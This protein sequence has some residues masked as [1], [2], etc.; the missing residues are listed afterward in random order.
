MEP[1]AHDEYSVIFYEGNPGWDKDPETTKYYLM[2]QQD[3]ANEKLKAQGYLFLNDVYEMLGFNKT[4]AG[5]IV[6]WYYDEKNP[7]GSNY[8]DFGMFDIYNKNKIDFINGDERAIVLDF[9][10]DGNILEYI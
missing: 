8:V 2:R 3:W 7:V 5:Q 1:T 9:N 4:K 10:I 6:G